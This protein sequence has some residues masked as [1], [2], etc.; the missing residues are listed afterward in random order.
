VVSGVAVE[1]VRVSVGATAIPLDAQYRFRGEVPVAP[2]D[3][4]I[5]IRIA[6]PT[7][8]VDYYLRKIGGT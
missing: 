6:H 4:S 3:R 5:A 8:G 7:R 2:G 1:G